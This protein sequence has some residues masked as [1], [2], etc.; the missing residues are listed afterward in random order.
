MRCAGKHLA[1]AVTEFA[2]ADREQGPDSRG[3]RNTSS[4]PPARTT[5]CG[6]RSQERQ[7]VEGMAKGAY[8]AGTEAPKGARIGRIGKVAE[9]VKWWFAR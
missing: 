1:G 7:F 2:C 5:A 9:L 3:C 6:K 4:A 8:G